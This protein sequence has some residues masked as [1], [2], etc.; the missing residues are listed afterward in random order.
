MFCFFEG[1]H[2]FADAFDFFFGGGALLRVSTPQERLPEAESF[3]E[4][5]ADEWRGGAIEASCGGGIVPRNEMLW[6]SGNNENNMLIITS[7]SDKPIP[8]EETAWYRFSPCLDPNARQKVSV[9]GLLFAHL[10]Q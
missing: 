3:R 2:G 7:S 4:E 5:V 10:S 6:S 8:N 1:F 9:R